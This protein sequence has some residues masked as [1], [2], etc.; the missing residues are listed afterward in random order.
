MDPVFSCG[1]R[2][3][4][5][6][7]WTPP[8]RDGCVP[9]A[10]CG[11]VY[12]GLGLSPT[13]THLFI[14]GESCSCT[15][16]APQSTAERRETSG[17]LLVFL[18]PTL[19]S[20]SRPAQR[21]AVWSFSGFVATPRDL[22][23]SAAPPTNICSLLDLAPPEPTR[24]FRAPGPA[25]P[26][27]TADCST[28]C[29]ASRCFLRL[30]SAHSHHPASRAQSRLRPSVSPI[31]VVVSRMSKQHEQQQRHDKHKTLTT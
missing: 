31:A 8:R 10:R 7:W 26:H 5:V 30:S 14:L 3:L 15:C 6:V 29:E 25:A 11:C 24:V 1:E 4:T 12:T 22:R 27:Q 9:R 20:C 18:P 23:C 13:L 21:A 17:P 19:L 28:E 2:S 16:R